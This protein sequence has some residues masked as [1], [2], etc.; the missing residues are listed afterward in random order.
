MGCL[1]IIEGIEVDFYFGPNNRYDGFDLW[2]LGLFVSERATKYKDYTNEN[3]LKHDFNSLV[4]SGIIYNPGWF[5]G[6]TLY[7]FTD[8]YKFSKQ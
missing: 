6:D 7:Y 1:A 3:I 8:Q 5:P 2:R 4:N